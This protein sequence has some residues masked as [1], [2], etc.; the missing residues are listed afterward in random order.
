M[1]Y[2]SPLCEGAVIRR[3]KRFLCDVVLPDG[4][5]TTAHIANPGSMLTCWEPGAPCRLLKSDDPKRKLPWSVEQI[6]MAG[7]WI[8]VNT[9]RPNA[10]V[11]EALLA[12]RIPSLSMYPTVRREV[13]YG[14][15][16][17]VDFLLEGDGCAFVEV[18]NATMKAGDRAI[19]PDSVSERATKHLR[20]LMAVIDDRTRAVLLFHVGRT[21]V[22]AVAPADA[23]DPVYGRT[24]REA[25]AAGVELLAYRAVPGAEGVVLGGAVQVEL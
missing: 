23:I 19:F 4:S 3:Y 12:G 7:A 15:D 22:N 1:Q 8:V 6:Q 18:K 16:S 14:T 20:E 11:G 24:L 5:E 9:G 21:D 25:A 17:R 10:I 13:A 2:P